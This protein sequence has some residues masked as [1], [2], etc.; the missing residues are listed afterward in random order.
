MTTGQAAT[1]P[2]AAARARAATV[3][4]VRAAGA[5]DVVSLRV[6]DAEPWGRCRPG[7][8]V[9]VPVGPGAGSV[10]PEV[11]WVAGVHGDP[12]HG[13]TV[14]LLLPVDRGTEPG[15]EWRLLGPMGRG[16]APPAQ[17]V[18][19]LLVGHEGG[20]VPL[21][22]LAEQLRDRGCPVHVLLSASDPELH[23]DLVHLRRYARSVVLALPE[24]LP[25]ALERLLDDPAVDPAVVYAA[26][27]RPVLREVAVAGLGRQRVVRV[28]A[29]DL[30]APV[31][32]GTGLCGS[33]DLEVGDGAEGSG[34]VLR[35]CLE[36]PVVPGELL[37]DGP[38]R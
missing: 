36:G 30:E 37:V 11:H 29:L 18:P 5:H 34:G 1:P 17:P 26:A 25:A 20:A 38:T 9:V 10:L 21:R 23:L 7:Q 22:W 4:A 35:P 2:G 15:E 3:T 32:C 19:V 12:V 16:F 13:T 6:P 27:P 31:V 14:E 24:D 8:F 28:A 33:C